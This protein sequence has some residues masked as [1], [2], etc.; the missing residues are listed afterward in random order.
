M[1]KNK[2][3][4]FNLNVN[5]TIKPYSYLIQRKHGIQDESVNYIV[6]ITITVKTGFG[7]LQIASC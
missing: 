1:Y 4:K 6:W 7:S 5:N 2:K 3:P